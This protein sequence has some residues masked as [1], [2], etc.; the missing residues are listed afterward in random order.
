MSP[1]GRKHILWLRKNLQ[2]SI[3]AKLA[4]YRHVD[5]EFTSRRDHFY[6]G[7]DLGYTCLI[8]DVKELT[9]RIRTNVQSAV[10]RISVFLVYSTQ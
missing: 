8:K 7:I 2:L 10:I 1:S 9:L 5:I 3:S 4:P 6:T